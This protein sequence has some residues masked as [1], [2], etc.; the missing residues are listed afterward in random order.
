MNTITQECGGELFTYDPTTHVLVIDPNNSE[1]CILV[2]KV[3]PPKPPSTGMAAAMAKPAKKEEKKEPNIVTQLCGGET[4]TYNAD[5]HVLV[6]DPR[7]NEKCMLIAKIKPV[8]I[9]G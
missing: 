2:A 7:D 4:F 1:K 6:S 5:T 9:T 3:E 8:D